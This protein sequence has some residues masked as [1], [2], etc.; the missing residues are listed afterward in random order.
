M[1]VITTNLQPHFYYFA[2][3]EERFRGI[4]AL[5]LKQPRVQVL[6]LIFRSMTLTTLLSNIIFLNKTE[7]IAA[8]IF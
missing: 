3:E 2:G 1:S 4:M 6:T 7:V 5:S 8:P